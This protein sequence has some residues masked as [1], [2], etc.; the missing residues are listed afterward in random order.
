V[1]NIKNQIALRWNDL[2]KD[3]DEQ[4]CHGI[5]SEEEKRQ[6]KIFLNDAAG[7]TNKKILDV[8]TGTGFLAILLAELGN[9]CTGMDISEGMMKV[10]KKKAEKSNLNIKFCIGDAEN[11][12]IEDNSYDVVVNR[13]LLWTIPHPE[14]ALNEWIRVLKPGGKLIILDGDWFYKNRINDLK[15]WLGNLLIKMKD[16]EDQSKHNS[17]YSKE[18]IAMLPMMKDENARNVCDLVK[19]S[20]LENVEV[21]PITEVDKVEKEAMPFRY[22][23]ANTHK[24]IC[25]TGTKKVN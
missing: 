21:K 13:H 19:N 22:R 23:L 14:K 2:S 10:A 3:Y 8:G 17:N 6:W 24:R 12:P 25:I 11:L 9:N 7:G 4:Y 18:V 16:S 5:K 20:G 1:D 15:I